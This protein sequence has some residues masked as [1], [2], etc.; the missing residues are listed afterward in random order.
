MVSIG[1]GGDESG[2]GDGASGEE[3]DPAGP[4]PL[5]EV[6]FSSAVL[7]VFTLEVL[8]VLLSFVLAGELQGLE[9]AFL[10]SFCATYRAL[11]MVL[12]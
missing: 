5:S 11:T 6:K 4:D 9:D 3:G 1:Q 2:P 8:V 10:M 7:Y 12:S